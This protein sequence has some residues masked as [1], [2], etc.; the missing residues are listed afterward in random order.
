MPEEKVGVIDDY[1][2]HVGVAGVK[3]TASLGV[4]DAI[5]IEGHTTN[6]QQVVESMQIERVDVREAVAGASVGIKVSERC[7]P[8]DEV[9]KII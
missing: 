6:F 3:L 2:A 4:G 7:R 8:G 1:F 5:H 9:Y